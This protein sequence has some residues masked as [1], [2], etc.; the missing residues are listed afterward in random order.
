MDPQQTLNDLIGA[1]AEGDADRVRE[2]SEALSTW[3]ERGGFPPQTIG[4]QELGNAWHAT[5]TRC[6]CRLAPAHVR[7]VRPG[8]G[9]TPEGGDDAAS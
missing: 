2:L 3:I 4:P 5:I 1:M 7:P 8:D 6:V 9:D